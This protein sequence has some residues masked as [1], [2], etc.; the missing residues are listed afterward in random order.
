MK[1]GY[2]FLL[3]QN[4]MLFNIYTFVVFIIYLEFYVNRFWR[5]AFI[6]KNRWGGGEGEDQG[7]ELGGSPGEEQEGEEDGDDDDDDY[8]VN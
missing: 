1:I 5:C 6:Y 4:V 8:D 3:P 2:Y 7:G